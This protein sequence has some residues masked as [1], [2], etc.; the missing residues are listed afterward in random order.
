[1]ALEKLLPW[2]KRESSLARRE[3][4]DPFAMMRREM[5]RLFENFQRDFDLAP[6]AETEGDWAP[7]VNV[8]QTD[9]DIT[10]TAELPGLDEKDIDISLSKD[11][12]TLK[13]HKEETSEEKKK[14]Y[15]YAERTYG[16]FERVIQLPCEV[17][18]D[19]VEA[20][21]NKGVLTIALPKSKKALTEVKKIAV[22]A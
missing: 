15:Y 14:D 9:K 18:S 13:G 17:E 4:K 11:L 7:A 19:K 10:V 1:M 12:L 16:A 6:F 8:A 22:K 2:K 20:K 3:E 21:F 5:N